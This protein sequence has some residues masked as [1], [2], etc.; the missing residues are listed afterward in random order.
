MLDDIVAR[1]RALDPDERAEIERKA[2]EAT[3]GMLWVPNPGPQTMA[4]F[5]PAD[6]LFFGGEPGGGKSDLLLG[7]ALN[8]HRRSQVF[9]LHHGDRLDLIER[10]VGILGSRDGYNGAEHVWRLKQ[11]LL[12]FG[13]L[14]DPKAWQKY[15]GRAADFKAW[16]ELA[17][18]SEYQFRTVNAWNRTTVPGQRCRVVGAGNPPMTPE[19]VWVV[20]YFAPW[21]DERHPNPAADGELRWFTR[22]KG[23]EVE[24]DSE[25]RGADKNGL[26]VLPKSRTFIRST[27]ADNPDLADSG[28][29]SQLSAL[30]GPLAALAEGRFSAA[31]DDDAWQVISAQWVL[32]AQ[33][34]WKRRNVEYEEGLA[35]R[36]PMHAMGVDVAMGG[37]DRLV[38]APRYGTFF[39]E[40]VEEE[41]FNI[42]NPRD[43]VA[44]VFKHA[45]DDA[46]INVDNTGGW[47]TGVVEHLESNK[48]PCWACVFSEQMPRQRSREGWAFYNKRAEYYWRLREALDPIDGDDIALPPGRQLLAE[49]TAPRW[50]QKP[51]DGRN[52]IA[53]ETKEDIAERL[54]RSPD[55]ADAVVLAWA[56]QDALA[57]NFRR[58]DAFH[59]LGGAPK[60]NRANAQAKERAKRWRRGRE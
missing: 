38:L 52:G 17:Q 50:K 2:A 54:G 37:K 30:T 6:V 16:D 45:T 39:D 10:L 59:R 33:Q 19:G 57:T 9:R 24:V 1:L 58:G 15:Q 31:L 4:Y 42:K 51:V 20:E 12:E 32:E 56:E 5:S 13:A 11:R 8:E 14:S 34:R 48:H 35:D 21:L 28:Y 53:I 27:L 7:L 40:L 60:A 23:E 3:S 26:E 55:L 47:G 22:I 49:L 36:G 41:G 43:V 46:Q 18:F 44:R 25:W 29:A